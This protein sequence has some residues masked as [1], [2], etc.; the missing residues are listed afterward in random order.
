MYRECASVLAD[1]C[2]PYAPASRRWPTAGAPWRRRLYVRHPVQAQSIPRHNWGR[3]GPILE[4]CLRPIPNPRVGA[5]TAQWIQARTGPRSMRPGPAQLRSISQCPSLILPPLQYS[6]LAAGFPPVARRDT[7]ALQEIEAEDAPFPSRRVST[8]LEHRSCGPWPTELAPPVYVPRGAPLA[9]GWQSTLVM[10][11]TP[12]PAV[13]G[14]A[15]TPATLCGYTPESRRTP[16]PK[17]PAQPNFRP[18]SS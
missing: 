18:T 6:S 5:L 12:P 2:P 10:L 1:P 3:V 9:M 13:R 11:S 15:R 8:Q 16:A 14:A 4:R 17:K 7:A